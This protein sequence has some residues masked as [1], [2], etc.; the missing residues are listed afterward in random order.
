MRLFSLAAPMQSLFPFSR[1]GI[2]SFLLSLL[3]CL[4]T[5]Q[6]ALAETPAETPASQFAPCLAPMT[7]PEQM[8]GCFR[9]FYSTYPALA[10]HA[11]RAFELLGQAAKQDHLPAQYD[12]GS[13]FTRGEMVNKNLIAAN[14]W[15]Q[16]AAE[17]GDQQSQFA[18]GYN[19]ITL[20]REN[21][22]KD[23]ELADLQLQDSLHWTSLAAK[24]GQVAAMRLL[25]YTLL[26]FTKEDHLTARLWLERA[27]GMGDVKSMFYAGLAWEAHYRVQSDRE[28]LDKARHWFRQSADQGHAR[29][30]QHLEQLNSQ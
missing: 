22:D 18:L 15:L 24:G 1:P 20:Y 26:T 13:L 2:H 8:H 23:G 21:P 12:L 4:L 16:R 10:D 7:D 29:A 11:N 3:A 6:P 9:L 19:L 5:G 17:R 14:H 28:S 25:G 30:R 27:A